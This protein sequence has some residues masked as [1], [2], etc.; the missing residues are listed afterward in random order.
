MILKISHH[1]KCLNQNIT[2]S[3]PEDVCVL[4]NDILPTPLTLFS[5]LGRHPI[6]LGRHLC[7]ELMWILRDPQVHLSKTS[8]S[9]TT[10]EDEAVVWQEL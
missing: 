4:L 10:T 9:V 1:W 2:V 3:F 6:M 5:L 8:T 7:K